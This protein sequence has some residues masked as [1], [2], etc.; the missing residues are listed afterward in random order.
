MLTRARRGEM[1]LLKCMM[2]DITNPQYWAKLSL[3]PLMIAVFSLVCRAVFINS[4]GVVG[5]VEV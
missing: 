5:G 4:F 3:T 1:C 2:R